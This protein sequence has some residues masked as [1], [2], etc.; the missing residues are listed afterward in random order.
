MSEGNF[1]E[2]MQDRM[3]KTAI[4]PEIPVVRPEKCRTYYYDG[5]KPRMR[6]IKILSSARDFHQRT[7]RYNAN[8]GF[9]YNKTQKLDRYAG[10]VSRR[11][12]RRGTGNPRGGS[13][14][15]LLRT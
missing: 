6:K 9:F 7:N 14:S 5:Q 12:I 11:N 15:R 4:K 2:K 10:K 13:Y 1:L 3:S 8:N